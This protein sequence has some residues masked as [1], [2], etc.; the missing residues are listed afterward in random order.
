[1]VTCLLCL[2]GLPVYFGFADQLKSVFLGLNGLENHI[3]LQSFQWQDCPK[4]IIGLDV[5]ILRNGNRVK[6]KTMLCREAGRKL[7]T[8][9]GE[10]ICEHATLGG[11]AEGVRV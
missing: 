1:M 3:K 8:L 10:V 9:Y 7:C 4:P 11:H 6:V 2:A 5:H